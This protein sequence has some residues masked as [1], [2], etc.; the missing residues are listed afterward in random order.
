M[1]TLIKDN[2]LENLGNVIHSNAKKFAR[3]DKIVV[4]AHLGEYGNLNY[5]RPPIIEC[6]I[7]E[8]K[9]SGLN[10]F[11]FD[12]TS[13]YEG[14]RHSAKDY[15][16]TARKN[17]F[18]KET[19]GC[20]II[21]SNDSISVK[22]KKH[23]EKVNVSKHVADADGLVVVSHFKGHMCASFGGAIKNLGMGAVNAETKKAIHVMS[24]PR[25]T[26]KCK[27]CGICESV[28]KV[29]AISIENNIA[30]IDHDSCYGCCVCVLKC[31]NKAMVGDIGLIQKLLAESAAC[32]L[33]S[34]GKEKL[35]FVNVLQDISA[36][37][38]CATDFG[39]IICP[40]IGVVVSDNIVK[41]DRCSLDLANNA[42]GCDIFKK[43]NY[44]DPD[45]QIDT[46]IE[47]G[48]GSGGY[49]LNELS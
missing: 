34:F 26:G 29:G 13:W 35:I 41:A 1:C 22:G 11:I 28:C 21:I 18:T 47:Y 20:Q 49:K 14:H 27:G 9:K 32:V 7:S 38:D 10:P 45:I 43:T 19:M 5:V 6:I 8:L 4:K 30:H 31:P 48:L 16:D 36:L 44:L 25:V 40:D 33:D 23:L 39:N 3:G 37:C 2:I 24:Q 17:G 12:T 42:A 15:L 46:A